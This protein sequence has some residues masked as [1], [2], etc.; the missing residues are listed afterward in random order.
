MEYV[1]RQMVIIICHQ[2]QEDEY[3]EEG[4]A[5]TP[6]KKEDFKGRQISVTH[7]QSCMMVPLSASTGLAA[8]PEEQEEV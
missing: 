2:I 8:S 1:Q 6:N 3:V 7:E 4:K 5:I